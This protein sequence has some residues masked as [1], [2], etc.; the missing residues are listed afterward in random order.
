[1]GVMWRVSSLACVLSAAIG[2]GDD[3]GFKPT[4]STSGNTGSNTTGTTGTT[5]AGSGNTSGGTDAGSNTGFGI[6]SSPEC[7]LNGYWAGRLTTLSNALGSDQVAN[8]WYWMQIAQHGDSVEVIDHYDCGVEVQ[9]LT[10]SAHVEL[11]RATMEKIAARNRQVGRKGT[12]KRDGDSC[13]LSMERFWSVRGADPDTY[14]PDGR[15]S[16]MTLEQAQAANALPSEDN[17]SGAEDWNGS[18]YAGLGLG[19]VISGIVNGTRWSVQ[20][21][22][23]EWFSSSEHPVAA[24]D[25]DTQLSAGVRFTNEESVI[26][27]DP[28]TSGLLKTA[29][30]PLMNDVRNQIT[31]KRLGEAQAAELRDLPVGERCLQVQQILTFFE[32]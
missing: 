7:D 19:W 11:P 14:L 18:D 4:G 2:C 1:M 6:A 23:N 15:A 10:V 13:E 32:P 29:G 27:I 5:D 28:P 31:L 17:S 8:N 30:E 3:G 20:R 25:T 12:L 9:G 26:S 24:G 16:T 22:W 21:D